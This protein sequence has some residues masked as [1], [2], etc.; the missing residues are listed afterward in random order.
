MRWWNTG[1]SQV[2]GSILRNAVI[3]YNLGNFGEVFDELFEAQMKSLGWVLMKVCQ[4]HG[5]AVR[6]HHGMMVSVIASLF[7][8][9]VDPRTIFVKDKVFGV[10]HGAPI[11]SDDHPVM[12]HLITP[13]FA[14]GALVPTLALMPGSLRPSDCPCRREITGTF[15]G[16]QKSNNSSWESHQ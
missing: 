15:R 10:K 14:K 16:E 3:K 7:S 13:P 8:K 1:S 5:H 6:A 2:A 11:L 4:S 9:T 12:K